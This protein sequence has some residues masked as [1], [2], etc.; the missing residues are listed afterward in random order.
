MDSIETKTKVLVANGSKIFCESLCFLL[1][2]HKPDCLCFT[3]FQND[4]PYPDI[5][6]FE[7]TQSLE[8]LKD[9]YP[10]AKTILLDN[11]LSEQEI[12]YLLL[13]YKVDG[14]IPSASPIDLFLKALDVVLSGQV[15][16]E[17]KHLKALL[18]GSDSMTSGGGIKSLS[19]QDRR[20]VQLVAKGLKNREIA[21]QL[22][23]SEHTI[24]AHIS[25]IFR[26][27]NLKR[28]AQLISLALESNLHLDRM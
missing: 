20:I 4:I 18:Q 10:Q 3:K 14:V 9:K 5:I 11:G 22:C 24:K 12:I 6:I 15:W 17:N 27:L 13:T 19:V 21:E 26:K 7:T 25:R 16:I 28:R 1:S 23:L 2:H 8:L